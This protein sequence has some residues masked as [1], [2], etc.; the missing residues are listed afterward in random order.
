MS[1]EMNFKELYDH[2]QKYIA[3]PELRWKYTLRIKRGRNP[4]QLGGHAKDQCYFRG[5]KYI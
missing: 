4:T 3:D 1:L 5:S 2:L